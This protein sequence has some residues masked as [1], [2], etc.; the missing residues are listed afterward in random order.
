VINSLSWH[1][2]ME[3]A[4][5]GTFKPIVSLDLSGIGKLMS[6][7]E[8][9]LFDFG[10]IHIPKSFSVFYQRLREYSQLEKIIIT[11]ILSGSL[12]YLIASE[13]NH[14]PTFSVITQGLSL[15]PAE[16]LVF[17]PY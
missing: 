12:I 6:A 1:I 2:L 14:L 8:S 9:N 16:Q 17:F 10:N 5:T 11:T 13:G 7:E 3:R 15:P 4:N